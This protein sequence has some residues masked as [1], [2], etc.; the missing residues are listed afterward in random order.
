MR[1]VQE[2]DGDQVFEIH[3]FVRAEVADIPISQYASFHLAEVVS[4]RSLKNHLL[5]NL[6]SLEI[7]GF[8]V[9]ERSFEVKLLDLL[10]Y[11]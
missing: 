3:R 5:A 1:E 8:W 10:I 2:L 9:I 4:V 6:D 7:F 11:L